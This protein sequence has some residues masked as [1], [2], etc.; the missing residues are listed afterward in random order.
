MKR[1]ASLIAG[2]FLL[3]GLSTQAATGKFESV[4][5]EQAK[6]GCLSCHEGIESIRQENST[7]MLMIKAIGGGH[8]D[9]NGCIVCHGGNQRATTKQDAHSG[10]PETLKAAEGPQMFYPDPGAMVINKLT[11][12]QAGCHT[13][14]PERLDKSLMNT[15]AGKIQ[16][17][18]HT[19]GFPEMR[20]Y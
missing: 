2:A 12:G 18:L 3:S 19:W 6:K 9:P 15:E 11:C 13:G 4:T 8:G 7:M 5:P 10:S 14:Y 1:L 16:G 20:D 17:N